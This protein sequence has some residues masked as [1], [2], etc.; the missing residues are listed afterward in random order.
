MENVI[1]TNPEYIPV[2]CA[3]GGIIS[4]KLASSYA[5]C[6]DCKLEYE[7]KVREK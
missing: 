3:C 6:F 5:F 2:F 7:F 4:S 1:M